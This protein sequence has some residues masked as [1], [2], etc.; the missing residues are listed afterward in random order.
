MNPKAFCKVL[1]LLLVPAILG[2]ISGCSKEPEPH[3]EQVRY[4]LK[5]LKN[6]SVVGDLYASEYGLFADQ[7]L[8]V[9]TEPGGPE[10]DPIKELEIGRAQF[11]VASADQVIRAIS[12]GSPIVVVAQLFQVNPLQWI[13]RSGKIQIA[14][15]QDLKGKTIGITYGG[16]DE[17]IMRTLLL[18]YGINSNEVKLFSVRYDYSPFY[19]GD[20]DLWP[21]YRNAEGIVIA[22]KLRQNGEEADFFNPDKY[23][24]HFV[25]NSVVTTE[26]MV[27][28]HPETVKKFINALRQGWQEALKPENSDK[29]LAAVHKFDKDT[30]MDVLQQQL[31]A[32]RTLME[33]P[34]G[35]A[36][37]SID[38][39]AWKQT[40]KIML[41]Q[42]LI[43]APVAVEQFLHQY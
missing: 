37:G 13:Y 29:A 33:P 31:T 16:N 30:P 5:W 20:V 28:Q 22:D 42:K 1:L 15:P 41:E 11:G 34:D 35:Q 6:I 4:R 9:D 21:V 17:T 2:V 40:E 12:K 23:G 3:Q 18:K 19:E 43:A 26:Q 38:V 24:V 27:K 36:F 25:A 10:R 14:S 32:T 7:G 8:A 39:E